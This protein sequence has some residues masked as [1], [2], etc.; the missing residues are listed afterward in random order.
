MKPLIRSMPRLR[1]YRK[2]PLIMVTGTEKTV[3]QWE[4]PAVAM[5]FERW[6]YEKAMRNWP[7]ETP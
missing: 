7:I 1:Q 3:T 4:D 2:P 5:R 6:E